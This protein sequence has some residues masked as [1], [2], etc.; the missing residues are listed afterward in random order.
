MKTE[1][2]QRS[3]PEI[4]GPECGRANRADPKATDKTILAQ[5]PNQPVETMPDGVDHALPIPLFALNDHELL[6][7]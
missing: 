7:G 5:Q 4:E 3:L 2:S 1:R 6:R